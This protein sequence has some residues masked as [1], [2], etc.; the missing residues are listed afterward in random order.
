MPIEL[1]KF[2]YV[3]CSLISYSWF[4]F[5]ILS[6]KLGLTKL[7]IPNKMAPFSDNQQ[8]RVFHQVQS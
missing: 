2:R 5:S 6:I 7:I 3:T 4:S 8:L 1:N